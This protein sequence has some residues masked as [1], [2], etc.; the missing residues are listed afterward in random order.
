MKFSTRIAVCSSLAALLL[1]VPA[2]AQQGRGGS[3]AKLY[4]LAKQKL[5]EGKQVNGHSIGEFNPKRYCQ[6]GPHYDFR[7]FEMPAPAANLK[8]PAVNLKGRIR[9]GSP[10]SGSHST[11]RE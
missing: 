10:R 5:R 6:E 9:D 1:G 7:W 3:S 8:R 4:N 2:A 11:N